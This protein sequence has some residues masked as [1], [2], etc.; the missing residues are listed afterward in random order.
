MAL[1][2]ERSWWFDYDIATYVING[3]DERN[4]WEVYFNAT[5]KKFSRILQALTEFG[6][7]GRIT[8]P[9]GLYFTME[10]S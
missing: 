9:N 3:T 6:K 4:I 7:F 10:E 2:Q 8:D 5:P 1:N